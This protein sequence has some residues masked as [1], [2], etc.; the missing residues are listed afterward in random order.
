VTSDVAAACHQAGVPVLSHLLE[1]PASI[2]MYAGRKQLEQ[3]VKASQRIVVASG[4][5]RDR[6]VQHYDLDP[7]KFKVIYAGSRSQPQLERQAAARQSVLAE[8]E[9]PEDVF[10]VLGCGSVHPRKGPDLFVQVAKHLTHMEFNQPVHWIWIGADQDSTSWRQWCEHDIKV[11]G[12][13]HQVQFLGPRPMEQMPTYML[14]A[15][16]FALTSREDPFPL[17]NLEAMAHGLPIVAFADAGGAPEALEPDAGIVLP[18]LDAKAMAHAIAGLIRNP[19]QRQKL[20]QAAAQASQNY[21]QWSRYVD[22]WVNL[23]ES[24]FGYRLESVPATLS[25]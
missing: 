9:L 16:L 7:E 2:E 4:Y 24:E 1:L 22:D 21:Y 17:V 11:A 19:S 5:T 25:S 6:I 8:L 13:D 20:S 15:D 3:M 14:A 10:L 18:Y 23:L 12:L